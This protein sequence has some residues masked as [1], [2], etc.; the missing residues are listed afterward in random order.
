[1]AITINGDGTLTGISVGGLPDGIV[2]TDM[3]AT[4]AVSAAK[5]QSTAIASGDLPAGSVL[6]V[7]QAFKTNVYSTTATQTWLDIT[8]LSVTITPVAADSNF[9]ITA[10]VHSGM[11]S[12]GDIQGFRF[13][14][15]STAIALG[16]TATGNQ[17]NASF[18]TDSVA[19]Q[20]RMVNAIGCF[21][22]ED[23]AYT[24]GNSLT[25]KLQMLNW[26][27]TG[28]INQPNDTTADPYIF[29]TTSSITVMEIAT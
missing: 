2:D 14:R 12:T 10:N 18:S 15:G 4:D 3:L 24:L 25:Y 27:G 1:M 22:D 16:T 17:N 11:S 9:L 26:D 19:N 6:Q 21:L 13:V 8:G 28:T 7:Q 23:P 20:S 29:K 5:L